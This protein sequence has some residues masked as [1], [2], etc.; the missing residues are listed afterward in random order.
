[1]SEDINGP[2]HKPYVEERY[3]DIGTVNEDVVA[4]GAEATQRVINFGANLESKIYQTNPN[5]L[6]DNERVNATTWTF[7][8]QQRFAHDAR[9]MYGSLGST[10]SLEGSVF[11]FRQ[12]L[13]K[14]DEILP[15]T[16]SYLKNP[17]GLAR[18]GF[19]GDDE[20]YR[21][22]VNRRNANIRLHFECTLLSSE[23]QE[24]IA[25]QGL[26]EALEPNADAGTRQAAQ[27][28]IDIA[29]ARLHTSS[30]LI[31]EHRDW[32]AFD[33]RNV[34]RIQAQAFS[35]QMRVFDMLF[36]KLQLTDETE[37]GGE[38]KVAYK[39][40][41]HRQLDEIQEQYSA[42]NVNS[43]QLFEAMAI[44]T[45]RR[46]L[47]ATGEY[48][49][50]YTRFATAR[51]DAPNDGHIT[52]DQKRHAFDIVTVIN[53]DWED[54]PHQIYRYQLKAATEKHWLEHEAS[55]GH[56]NPG[57]HEDIEVVFLNEDPKFTSRTVSSM[58]GSLRQAV[59][60]TTLGKQR[61]YIFRGTNG[62]G[63]ESSRLVQKS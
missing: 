49:T 36:A 55:L 15:D 48:R 14:L 17:D 44:C 56:K 63:K 2:L 5:T 19:K 16:T 32:R 11:D 26:D 45:E 8:D 27:D 18:E 35:Y 38:G 12:I 39:Q 62:L 13:G 53:H 21:E 30:K 7:E 33:A 20:R 6:I 22:A 57:Y 52:N 43:G 47:L 23:L 10:S 29:I 24:E 1:M 42:G 3:A 28:E 40:L 61:K 58:I 51:E 54:N 60:G 41:I 34:E 46:R 4:L 59:N 37:L 25:I 50:S 31:T 9:E